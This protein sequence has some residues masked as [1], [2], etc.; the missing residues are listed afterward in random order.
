MSLVLIT[1]TLLAAAV[2]SIHG[3]VEPPVHAR[4]G[5]LWKTWIEREQEEDARLGI[6]RNST[7]NIFNQL[8]NHS[9]PS[10]GTFEQYYY[11]DFSNY[12]STNST[13]PFI[14]YIG[15]EGPM[16]GTPGGY[17]AVVAQQFKGLILSLEHRWYGKSLPGSLTDRNLLSTLSVE[18]EMADLAAFMQYINQQL[19]PTNSHPWITVGGSY[20]GALSAWVRE[21]HPELTSMSWSS[22]GV[23][24]ALFDYSGFD[25][26]L[27]EV[28][29]EACADNI[30]TAM[31]AAS[32]AWDD[33][34]KKPALLQMFGTPDYFLKT[35]FAWM[36]ADSVAMGDQYGSKDLLCNYMTEPASD[37]LSQLANWTNAHYGP[38]F[39]SSC[40]YSTVCLSDASYS[41]QWP[42]GYQWVYQCCSELA[43]WQINW[44][45]Q[46]LRLP[47]LTTDYFVSQCQ[48]AFGPNTYPN[49]TAFNNRFNGIN[50][51]ATKVI[52]LQGSD[53]PWNRAGIQYSRSTYPEFNA[54]CDGCGHCGDLRGPS[55]T[56]NPAITV[57]HEA[58]LT[59]LSYW[60]SSLT[61]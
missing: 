43:Y 60:L 44:G 2:S 9:A 30:R 35:D 28:I 26:Q 5:N 42:D 29:P 48:S 18:T 24:N 12:D 32:D 53:D 38:S 22:S 6:L 16:G 40:Y 31:Q 34:S 15:G 11:V 46:S 21:V 58:I 41:S 36:I 14:L 25:Q 3:L 50:N 55:P 10:Q 17:V 61:N 57:Q 56:E 49:T 1:A 13:T 54:T 59:Y 37:P 8:V 27:V 20:A 19:N 52:A 39:G 7:P 23:V 33:P 47:L 51:N 45:P 4:G